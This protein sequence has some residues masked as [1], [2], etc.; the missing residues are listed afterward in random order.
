MSRRDIDRYR[1][2]V[3]QARPAEEFDWRIAVDRSIEFIAYLVCAVVLLSAV[4]V[5]LIFLFTYG[6]QS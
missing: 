3:Y 5:L 6:V 1:A 2:A 4:M